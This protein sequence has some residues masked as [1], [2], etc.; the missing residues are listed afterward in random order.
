MRYRWL[1]FPEGRIKA[2]TFSY[3]DGVRQ[4]IRLA[5]IFNRNGIKGTF[6]INSG[7]TGP[8]KLTFE[9]MREH[10]FGAGHEI[11]V[12]GKYHVASGAA[13]PVN[14]IKDALF[15]RME[16]EQT[17]DTIIRG[18]AYPDS[19]IR[20]IA[21][22]NS[23]ENVRHSLSSLGI[24]YSRTLG[25]DNN[26]FKLPTDWY[27]WIPTA[28]HNNPSLFEW[29]DSFNS[30]DE[31]CYPYPSGKWPRLMYVWG[32]SYEFDRN[33]NWDRIEAICE[34]LGGREDTWYATNIEIYDYVKAYDS[35]IFSA[36]DTKVYNPTVTK[37][38]F[39]ADDKIYSVAP[40]E[41]LRIEA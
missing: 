5:E 27:A 37:V 38:W 20:N 41:T 21:N 25:Q 24:A 23:Y 7:F 40:G 11:A 31:S 6:N 28:H 3:D 39:Y 34:K 2:V 22:G 4:D 13:T 18:M 36:D 9:E 32:H 15:C 16:L 17:F 14:C 29:I 33:D 12:H 8:S 35:L 19:G 30:V 10:L 1:R 26:G